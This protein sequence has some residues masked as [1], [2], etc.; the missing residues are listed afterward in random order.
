MI[1]EI[2]PIKPSE[3][4]E[5]KLAAIPNEMIQAINDCIVKYWDGHEATF[6]QDELIEHYFEITGEP[7]VAGNREK[8]FDNHYLN[9]EPIFEKEGWNV[10]YDRPAFNESYPSTFTFKVKKQ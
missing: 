3:V 5:R 6:K 10:K 9:F 1:G 4:V 2:N 8:L 7:N